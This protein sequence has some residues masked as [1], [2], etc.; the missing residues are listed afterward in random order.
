VTIGSKVA[1]GNAKAEERTMQQAREH[2]PWHALYPPGCGPRLERRPASLLSAFRE[3]VRQVGD[4]TFSHYFETT[5]SFRQLDADSDALAAWLEENGAAD[6]AR[7]AIIA[8]NI[9]SFCTAALAAWKTGAIPVPQ[10]PM[11]RAAE[12]GRILAD[13]APAVVL[14]QDSE[15]DEVAAALAGVMLAVPILVLAPG[16][17]TGGASLVPPARATPGASL[18]SDV[19]AT[20]R[21]RQPLPRDPDP[22]A[23]ALIL[24]TSGTTGH[25]KGAMLSHRALA[26]NACFTWQW[27]GLEEGERVLAIAPLFHIT[28]FVCH[29]GV[30]IVARASMVMHYRF[31]PGLVLEMIRRWRPSFTIGAITAFNALMRQPSIEPADMACFRAIFSGGA[32]IPPALKQEIEGA[33]GIRLHPCYGM[34][35]TAA[36]AVF[37]PPGIDAPVLDGNLAI[38]VPIPD[39]DIR[40]VDE[41]GM[42]VP[43]GMPGELLMRGPQ[44]M[45]GYWRKPQESAD[46]L[47]DG[48]MHSGDVGIMDAQGW[49]YLV[50]RK[51]DVI[52]AS[53]FKV[54]PR[55]VED[56]LYA[57][58]G[59]REAAVVGV[60]DSYRGETVKAFVAAAA[61]ETIDPAALAAHC[62]ARL[63][64]YKVPRIIEVMPDLPKT[65]SGKIQ[66][67]ALR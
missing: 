67:A 45:Q 11:Y 44:V 18:L 25:P 33:L 23:T 57:F 50:D 61:G 43:P 1:M 39:T 12:L 3:A 58:P 66:R 54:W 60:Q 41:Q 13:A 2:Q 29:F 8:Q 65:V 34:T 49:L 27:C 56:V 55:E 22:D 42:P 63:A 19:L 59:V 21:G 40:I 37:T 51:K 26:H 47:D 36:P 6:G 17:G 24:Y 62:R 46:A 10:N 16:E 9:P 30:A 15:Y 64:A 32:P 38:G 48:W 31:E 53:G 35:E 5:Q 14:C 4:A 20:H 7:V 52:I 28:G